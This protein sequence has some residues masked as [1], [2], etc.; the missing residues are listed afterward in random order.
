V[1]GKLTALATVEA[2]D[3]RTPSLR[4]GQ[5][6]GVPLPGDLFLPCFQQFLPGGELHARAPERLAGRSLGDIDRL[7]AFVLDVVGAALVEERFQTLW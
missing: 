7:P 6:E 3:H 2:L 1:L 5:V 4:P